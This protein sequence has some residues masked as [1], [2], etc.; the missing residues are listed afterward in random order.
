M[1]QDDDIFTKALVGDETIITPDKSS[2]PA[3]TTISNPIIPPTPPTPQPVV[4]KPTEPLDKIEIARMAMEGPERTAKRKEE[5]H[6]EVVKGEIAVI[7]KRL[8]EILKEKEKLEL[9]WV[10]LDDKRSAIKQ[11]L[12][13]IKE[14]EKAAEAEEAALEEE[15]ARQPFPK[16]KRLAE[17]KRW[18]V[19]EKRH[20]IETE[21][22]QVEQKM[23]TV[24][25]KVAE[26]TN[27]YQKFLDEEEELKTKKATLEREIAPKVEPKSEDL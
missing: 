1:P 3:P 23:M 22:W 19:Q 2:E 6:E 15:E 17:E 8:A 20:Q 25:E 9:A 16:E 18:P 5:E 12:D 10:D 24:E 4:T 14:K 13:P 11:T 26:N 21:K 7:D 27:A